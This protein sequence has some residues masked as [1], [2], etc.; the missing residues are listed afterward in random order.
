MRGSLG[1]KWAVLHGRVS[2]VAREP[3]VFSQGC[4]S[5]GR[6]Q[7]MLRGRVFGGREA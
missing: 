6:A 2:V 1:K 4:W 3:E 7:S 5:V